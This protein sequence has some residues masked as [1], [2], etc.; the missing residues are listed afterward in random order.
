MATAEQEKAD[1]GKDPIL[2]PNLPPSPAPDPPSTL[3][4]VINPL[5]DMLTKLHHQSLPQV[6]GIE[7]TLSDSS[8]SIHSVSSTFATSKVISTSQHIVFS[9]SYDSSTHDMI[10]PHILMAPNHT[11]LEPTLETDKPDT[12][13]TPSKTKTSPSG[14]MFTIDDIPLHKWADRFQ[15]FNAW[16]TMKNLA[17][18]S[19]YDILTKFVS[20][21]QAPLRIGGKLLLR[22]IRCFPLPANFMKP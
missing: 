7:D 19:T 20:R 14:P 9:N 1:K 15:Q 13:T 17:D 4:L 6:S 3:N 10:Q 12:Y 16:M 22:P 8:S 11:V 21:L 2:D 18:E 5:S